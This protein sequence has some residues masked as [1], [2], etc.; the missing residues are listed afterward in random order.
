MQNPVTRTSYRRRR[1]AATLELRNSMICACNL[2][3]VT[4]PKEATKELPHSNRYKLSSSCF[5]FFVWKFSWISLTMRTI[6]CLVAFGHVLS[7]TK[8]NRLYIYYNE[9]IMKS[10]FSG[11]GQTILSLKTYVSLTITWCL[12]TVEYIYIFVCTYIEAVVRRA[13]SRQ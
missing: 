10:F 1:E 8:P 2:A 11:E 3:T 4:V 5:F 7:W 9:D 12:F 13:V 6:A